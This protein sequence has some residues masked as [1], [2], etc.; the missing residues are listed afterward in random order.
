MHRRIH[1]VRF[2][3]SLLVL[4]VL[5]LFILIII[6]LKIRILCYYYVQYSDWLAR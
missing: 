4:L 3:S 2:T 5:L 1:S 6:I